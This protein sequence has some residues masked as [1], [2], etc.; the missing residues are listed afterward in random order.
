M[1]KKLSKAQRDVL[2]EL[3]RPN[4]VIAGDYYPCLW[5]TTGGMLGSNVRPRPT[6]VKALKRLGYVERIQDGYDSAGYRFPMY[7]ITPTGRAALDGQ[8]G[9]R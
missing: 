1:S 3:L 5:R 9:A 7:R 4:A 8:D 2:T 6:T